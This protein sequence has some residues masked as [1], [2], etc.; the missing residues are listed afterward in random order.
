MVCRSCKSL[1]IGAGK[2]SSAIAGGVRLSTLIEGQE[3]E[4]NDCCYNVRSLTSMALCASI[5]KI[6]IM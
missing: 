6:C 2:F 1:E 4:W 5:G 3:V